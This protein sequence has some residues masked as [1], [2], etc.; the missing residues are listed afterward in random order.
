MDLRDD[1]QQFLTGVRARLTPS[2]AGVPDFGGQRRV[3]G[4]RREEV[5]QLAGVSTAYYTRMERGNL[6]GV[7]ESVLRALAR[8]LQLNG[9][10]TQH[11]F[12]LAR[13]S[14]GA[15][16]ARA[17][18]QSRLPQRVAQLLD[19]MPDVPVVALGRLGDL[20]GANGLGRALFPHVF[21]EKGEPLNHNR[22]LFLDPRSRE[23]YPHWDR[24]ARQALS[25]LRRLAGQNP[26]D[27]AL[28]ALVGE[29][30]TRSTEFRTWWAG[31]TVTVHTSGTKTFRHPVVGE[32]TLGYE[33]LTLGSAPDIRIATYLP[34]LG[35][36]S[37][38]A[39]ELLRSWAATAPEPAQ[40]DETDARVDRPAQPSA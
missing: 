23:F 3:P 7:S 35:T 26:D 27:P 1:V 36:P 14:D 13:A 19:T 9:V 29:L 11:L 6:R 16:P 5:A 8:A 38:D 20:V 10:E 17:K 40:A 33:T 18:P 15:T 12:D 22:Y 32:F 39:L 25:A 2:D 24:T 34:E 4:L 37:A 28:T 21:P 31:H 30:A